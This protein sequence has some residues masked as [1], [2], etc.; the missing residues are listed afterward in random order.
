MLRCEDNSLYTGITVDVARR[1]AEHVSGGSKGAKYTRSHKPIALEGLWKTQ[2]KAAAS[3]LEW[4]IKHLTRS[5]KDMLLQAPQ[6]VHDLAQAAQ[7]QTG[8][9]EV[10]SA[11]ERKQLWKEFDDKTSVSDASCS[12]RI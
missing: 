4:R 8:M 6:Q 7:K 9:F 12:D 11:Q 1:I 2:D 10:V 5:Q 3:W